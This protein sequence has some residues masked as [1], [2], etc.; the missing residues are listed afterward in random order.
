MYMTRKIKKN[1]KGELILE[2]MPSADQS[3]S[4]IN[5]V[6]TTIGISH[7]VAVNTPTVVKTTPEIDTPHPLAFKEVNIN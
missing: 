3:N 7:S 1:E 6:S 5:E 2:P 4:E